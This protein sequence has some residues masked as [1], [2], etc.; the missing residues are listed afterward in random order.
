MTLVTVANHTKRKLKL[1]VYFKYRAITEVESKYSYITNATDL[2]NKELFEIEV[3]VKDDMN[4][5]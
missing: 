5:N 3:E 2:K 4:D 1:V